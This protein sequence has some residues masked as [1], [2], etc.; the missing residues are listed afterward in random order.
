MKNEQKVIKA[1]L[2]T[3]IS[4]NSDLSR[5]EITEVVDLFF[6]A[7]KSALQKNQ[8]I[9][10]RGF[11]TFE[12]KTRKGREKARNPRTGETVSVKPHAVVSFRS[13]KD[14]KN[15]VWNVVKK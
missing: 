12:L 6:E 13:G 14:L 4:E 8:I 2:V 15:L 9:E 10:L 1:D 11:G 3:E 5:K 7:V